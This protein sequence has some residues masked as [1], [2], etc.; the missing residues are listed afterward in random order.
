MKTILINLMLMATATVSV[1]QTNSVLDWD[2]CLAQTRENNP[3]LISARSAIR[4]SEYSVISANAAFV[5]SVSASAGASYGESESG[6]DWNDSKSSNVGLS[7][8]QDLFSAGGN[9]ASKRKAVAQLKV[10]NEQY[11]QS[12]S[13]VELKV[14]LA[15]IDVLY[16]QDL[17]ELT[18]NIA[19]RR[20]NNV[21]LIQLRFDGGRENA[22]SLAR[23]K[24]QSAQAQYEVRA[25]KRSLEYALRNLAAAMGLSEPAGG[26]A[27]DL[28]ADAPGALG[29]L[30]ALMEQTPDYTIATVQLESAK[31]GVIIA[32]SS[33]FPSVGLSASAGLRSGDWE[34]YSGS[35]SLGLNA[36]MTLFDGGKIK[37]NIASAREQVIQ[38]E[39]GLLDT[40]NSLLASLQEQW[41]SYVNAIESESIQKQLYDAEILRGKISAAKYKQGLLDYE[42]WDDI[43]D[44]LISQGK[45]YLQAR[46]SSEMQ[47]AYWKN[48]LGLS[49][50]YTEQGE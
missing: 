33:R 43:E 49:V 25:A 48:A 24:A 13:A 41:N 36:S 17:V 29:D 15:F 35:W 42:D 28:K 18:E 39:M 7:L 31:E 12:L 47:Q 5:P 20:A 6:D 38:T 37:S 44:T 11:R 40:G 27:G 23:S 46:R 10:V 30:K 19:E 26:V 4:E 45:S 9:Q 21:R 1:A 2:E 3:D 14:R 32:R 8:S 34:S 50:W 16:A 22:G